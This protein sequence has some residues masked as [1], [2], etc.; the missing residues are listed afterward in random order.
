M[1]LMCTWMCLC[2]CMGQTFIF[3][4]ETQDQLEKTLG[5]VFFFSD[6]FLFFFF[7]KC[8]HSWMGPGFGLAI[9]V[10]YLGVPGL[11]ANVLQ[12]QLIGGS[13]GGSSPCVTAIHVGDLDEFPAVSSGVAYSWPLQVLGNNPGKRNTFGV[14]TQ[15][16]QDNSL[17]NLTFLVY[18]TLSQCYPKASEKHFC[19]HQ[20]ELHGNL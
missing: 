18:K 2:A 17:L 5:E 15:V 7:F 11:H 19:I 16:L 3:G 13:G 4:L 12:V 8:K 6:D 1:M 14:K 9:Q 20:A 10:L